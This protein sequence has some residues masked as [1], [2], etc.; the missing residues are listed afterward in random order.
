MPVSGTRFRGSGIP[1]PDLGIPIPWAGIAVPES[2]ISWR[3]P[4]IPVPDD[5]IR[6]PLISIRLPMS[7][8]LFPTDLS[9]LAGGAVRLHRS[10]QFVYDTAMSPE[11]KHMIDVLKTLMRVLGFSHRDVE[12]ELGV[13]Q[14]YLSRLFTGRLELRFDHVVD[15]AK[16][17]GLKPEEV[18]TYA[19]ARSQEPPSQAAIA[20]D[21][22]LGNFVTSGPSYRQAPGPPADSHPEAVPELERQV[23]LAMSKFFGQL[24]RAGEEM[25]DS[26]RKRR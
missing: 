9:T 7:R 8:I 22:R 20:L 14:S 16:V 10:V 3:E 1:L 26:D 11:T 13:S 25:A 5:F 18:F 4:R 21:E 6:S 15:I 17:M 12:K 24:A 19:F 23:A 2:G